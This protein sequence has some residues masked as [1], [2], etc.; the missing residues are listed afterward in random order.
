MLI[1]CDTCVVAGDACAECVIT[2]LLGR[3]EEPVDLDADEQRAIDVLA[4]AGL[5][6]RIRLVPVSSKSA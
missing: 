1:D 5:V 6:P 3:P 4:D 2:V